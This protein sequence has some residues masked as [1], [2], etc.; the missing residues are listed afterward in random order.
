MIEGLE[1]T[2]N[3]S[4]HHVILFN[5]CPE[6][7]AEAHDFANHIRELLVDIIDENGM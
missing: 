6:H 5:G 7:R 3:Q 1:F 2:T 4:F